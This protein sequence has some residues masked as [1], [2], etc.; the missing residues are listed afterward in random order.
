MLD[1]S[2]REVAILA[3]LVLLTIFFG[4]Y[5]APVLDVTAASVK[6]LVQNYRG[7]AAKPAAALLAPLRIALNGLCAVLHAVSP[8]MI[9][10]VGAMALLM[11]GVFM[12]D[13]E[14]AGRIVSWLAIGVLA[15]GD[16]AACRQGGR[17][18]DR[19]RWRLRH[20]RL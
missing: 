13:G 18:G 12:R 7:G 16:V 8:E 6:N 19:V 1:L 3:P 15:A 14:A 2:P 10:A 17:N 4:F 20:R 5:P 9:L 11:F